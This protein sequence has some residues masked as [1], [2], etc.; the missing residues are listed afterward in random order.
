MVDYIESKAG[1][2]GKILIEVTDN[3]SKVG[4]GQAESAQPK[5]PVD[6]AFNQAMEAIQLTARS[7]LET[8]ETLEKKPDHVK[9]DFAIKIDPLAGAMLAK[10]NS[11]DVQL[12]VSLGWENTP[13]AKE[14]QK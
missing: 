4:F 3:R 11:S 1:K 7:V 10:A 9:I 13:P 12:K 8:L 2:D 14:E 6:D 5:P